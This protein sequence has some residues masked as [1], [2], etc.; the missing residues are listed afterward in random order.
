VAVGITVR[1]FYGQTVYQ[2]RE[3][4]VLRRTEA[5]ADPIIVSR[6]TSEP[7]VTEA[8]AAEEP[9]EEPADD[10]TEDVV[11]DTKE[12]NEN[13]GPGNNNGRGNDG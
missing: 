9:A 2:Q 10:L 6:S 4:L 5:G 11:E 7:V 3:D 1:Y 12:K 13:S 8:D